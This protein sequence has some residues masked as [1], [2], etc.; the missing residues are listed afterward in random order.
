MSIIQ[1]YKVLNDLW[2]KRL[3]SWRIQKQL[4]E[5][6]FLQFRWHLLISSTTSCWE[7]ILHHTDN[8]SRAIQK[9]ISSAQSQAVAAM[10]TSTLS[11]I[12]NE[13]HLDL[14]LEKLQ[15][16]AVQCDMHEPKLPQQRQQ[17][18]RYEEGA[19]A[20]LL[21]ITKDLYHRTYYEALDLIVQTIKHR[22]I[23]LAIGYIIAW[24]C[25]F[26][27]LQRGRIF[28]RSSSLPATSM[29]RIY[30]SAI[31]KCSCKHLLLSCRRK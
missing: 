19:P 27:W 9:H 24:K 23:G 14:F 28:Y 30:M 31:C 13:N 26:S 16:M 4:H 6:D 2:K 10:T 18:K 5:S 21:L 11:S 15:G 8:L 1:N 3:M 7:M 22:S 25:C 20:E 17:P 29:D 12:R